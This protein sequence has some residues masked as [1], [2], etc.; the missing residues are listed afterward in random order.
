[1]GQGATKVVNSN[2]VRSGAEAVMALDDGLHGLLIEIRF[3]GEVL[4]SIASWFKANAR[5]KFP[6][7]QDRSQPN[8]IE[9]VIHS[10]KII[11]ASHF[12]ILFSDVDSEADEFDTRKDNG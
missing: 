7:G 10:L 9:G 6:D 1:M 3:D 8:R 12:P 11:T 4:M 2:P 5:P